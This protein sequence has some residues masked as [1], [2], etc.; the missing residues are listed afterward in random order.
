MDVFTFGIWEYVLCEKRFLKSSFKSSGG[1]GQFSLNP[2]SD[3]SFL[4]ARPPAGFKQSR[5]E[6]NSAPVAPTSAHTESIFSVVFEI[7]LIPKNMN[8]SIPLRSGR[9]VAGAG[10]IP[11]HWRR[12]IQPHG[13]SRSYFRAEGFKRV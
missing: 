6:L 9:F 12:E 13:L 1:I 11:Y 2:I 10:Q 5:K 7:W 8:V 4:P 3:D